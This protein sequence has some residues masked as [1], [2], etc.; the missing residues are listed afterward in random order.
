MINAPKG[1]FIAGA[2]K[3]FP[4]RGKNRLLPVSAQPARA[5]CGGGS[6]SGTGDSHTERM[7][8]NA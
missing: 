5:F 2:E 1:P 3:Y 8:G 4:I 6:R 7:K